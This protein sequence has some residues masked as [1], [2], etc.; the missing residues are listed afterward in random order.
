MTHLD[1]GSTLDP[2]GI[3]SL[4][5]GQVKI[6][7]EQGIREVSIADP[8]NLTGILCTYNDD[9]CSAIYDLLEVTLT[10]DGEEEEAIQRVNR[11]LE[12]NER[13]I[14]AFRSLLFSDSDRINTEG[15][16]DTMLVYLRQRIALT[17]IHLFLTGE[18]EE[19]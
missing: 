12:E 3:G 10:G 13:I 7:Q 17:Q 15:T 16:V 14:L 18:D 2:R 1:G 5:H 11:A 8:Y 6:F 19:E 4:I 9:V